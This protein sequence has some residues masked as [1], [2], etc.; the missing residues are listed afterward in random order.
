MLNAV[1]NAVPNAVLCHMLCAGDVG[2]LIA[3]DVA[4]RGLD[5]PNVDLVV[6]YDMPQ[7][8]ES[9]LH[10]SGRTGRAGK[11]GR[12]IVMHTP[13]ETRALG[14]ILQ[15]V[16]GGGCEQQR[17]WR[18]W[19]MVAGTAIQLSSLQD[20]T[21]GRGCLCVSGRG[22]FWQAPLGAG[23]AGAAVLT[24]W[25]GS[26]HGSGQL[27]VGNRVGAIRFGARGQ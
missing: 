12:A 27:I 20:A 1:L 21:V 9:F 24:S 18:R 19:L 17:C 22:M 14:Q 6:H 2:V 13:S 7:D 26:G 3:T 23:K 15:Q 10:R 4:A 5:I 16:G 25:C 8:S 11:K